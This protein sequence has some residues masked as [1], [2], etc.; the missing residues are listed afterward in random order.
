MKTES[1]HKKKNPEELSVNIFK[2]KS[3]R[4]Q[5]FDKPFARTGRIV[6]VGWR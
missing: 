5:V 6:L 1:K 3:E 4:K 2:N